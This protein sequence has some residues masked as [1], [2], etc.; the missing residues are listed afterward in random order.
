MLS[1]WSF[2]EECVSVGLLSASVNKR[3]ESMSHEYHI[4][5]EADSFYEYMLK[6]HLRDG[7][8]YPCTS[9]RFKVARVRR[10]RRL[11]EHAPS[12]PR[13]GHD[14]HRLFAGQSVVRLVSA[15]AAHMTHECLHRFEL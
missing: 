5:G 7:G 3:G 11:L 2:D 15:E 9:G 1:V 6:T 13:D 10:G 4:G 14:F 8:R 12:I